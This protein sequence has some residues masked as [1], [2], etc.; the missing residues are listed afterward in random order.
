MD[1]DEY[2]ILTVPFYQDDEGVPDED[3]WPD[4]E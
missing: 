4:S 3:Y 1:E 2:G